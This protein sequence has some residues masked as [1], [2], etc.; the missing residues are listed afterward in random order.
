MPKITLEYFLP[1]D[2]HEA[3]I[4]QKSLSLVIAIQEFDNYLR[5]IN[6]YGHEDF[7]DPSACEAAQKIRDKLWEII[8]EARLGDIFN[9]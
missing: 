4:A 9:G 2:E 8:N 7:K 6:K 3:E 1:E 5:S